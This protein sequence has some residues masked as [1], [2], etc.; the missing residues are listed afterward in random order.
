M[1]FCN[2]NLHEQIN[3]HFEHHPLCIHICM[4]SQTNNTPTNINCFFVIKESSRNFWDT[5]EYSRQFQTS[6]YKCP[7][8]FLKTFFYNLFIFVGCTPNPFHAKY[9]G[10]RFFRVLRPKV[11]R[12]KATTQASERASEHVWAMEA[13][14]G[15]ASRSEARDFF[16]RSKHRRP[17]TRD[18]FLLS[19]AQG[20][21]PAPKEL[22]PRPRSVSRAKGTPFPPRE[23]L[24]TLL[25]IP[26]PKDKCYDAN[27]CKLAQL[28]KIISLCDRNLNRV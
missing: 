6:F 19:C 17:A 27:L 25:E 20:F 9:W 4:C 28:P 13:A 3:K 8:R 14:N 10:R 23:F 7:C 5:P 15:R 21:F 26:P 22:V 18:H 2:R 1:H 11:T 12:P 16:Q 24:H